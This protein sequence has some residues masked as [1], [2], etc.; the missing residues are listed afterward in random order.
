MLI[1]YL[2]V[3]MV[4]GTM[5]AAIGVAAGNPLW[6]IPLLYSFGGS[7]GILGLAGLICVLPRNPAA[8]SDR[9]G[10][11]QQNGAKA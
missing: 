5:L 4:S 7:L 2:F 11:A 9:N 10:S 1:S 3:G 6:S 8:A